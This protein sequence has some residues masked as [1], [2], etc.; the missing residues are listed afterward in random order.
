[1]CRVDLKKKIHDV[2]KD[3]Y[4]RDPDDSVD[5]SD[6]DDEHVHL[7]IV[8]RKFDGQKMKEKN[9]L[10]WSVLTRHLSPEE[11]GTIL[12]TVAAA[13]SKSRR[14]KPGLSRSGPFCSSVLGEPYLRRHQDQPPIRPWPR[15]PATTAPAPA[16]PPD[17]H[18]RSLRIPG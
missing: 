15:S 13:P 17:R 6:G 16:R 7:V 10:V 18:P 8:S 5:V 14:S 3:A 4:F 11:W 1:M 12:L 2:L 9:D